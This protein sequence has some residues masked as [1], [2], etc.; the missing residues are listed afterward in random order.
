ML[1]LVNDEQ[2][3]RTT[4]SNWINQVANYFE[5]A[6]IARIFEESPHFSKTWAVCFFF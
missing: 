2:T 6:R 5:K 1:V 3:D 4:F